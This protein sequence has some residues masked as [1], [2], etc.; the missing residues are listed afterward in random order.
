MPI[1]NGGGR[2]VWAARLGREMADKFFPP[3]QV[4]PALRNLE[5]GPGGHIIKNPR[6]VAGV[7]TG[8]V[9]IF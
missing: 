3:R 2:V 8:K 4:E 6:W 9:F 7:H 1:E 5:P